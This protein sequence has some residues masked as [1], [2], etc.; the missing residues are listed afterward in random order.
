MLAP[1]TTAPQPPHVYVLF[2]TS[3]PSLGS[4]D[5]STHFPRA[6][7]GFLLVA[8]SDAAAASFAACFLRRFLSAACFFSSSGVGGGFSPRSCGHRLHFS[9]LFQLRFE[10]RG[11][12]QSPDVSRPEPVRERRRP[13]DR[14]E[15]G[16]EERAGGLASSHGSL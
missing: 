5:P 7:T 3:A 2:S 8:A 14:E 9:R 11:H 16:E 15:H 10:Q 1:L 13:T 12:V 4:F 6:D